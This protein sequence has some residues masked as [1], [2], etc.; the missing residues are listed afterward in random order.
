MVLKRLIVMATGT[1][2]IQ[3]VWENTITNELEVI[4]MN[5]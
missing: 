2:N 3:N 1:A 4:S 5:I